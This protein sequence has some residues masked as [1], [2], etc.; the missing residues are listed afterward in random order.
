MVACPP[1]VPS[2]DAGRERGTNGLATASLTDGLRV[3]AAAGGRAD[4]GLRPTAPRDSGDDGSLL[5]TGR[6]PAAPVEAPGAAARGA[7]VRVAGLADPA[8]RRA[9]AW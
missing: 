9:T 5:S 8:E 7:A 6:S 3:P 2:D 1:V 4:C